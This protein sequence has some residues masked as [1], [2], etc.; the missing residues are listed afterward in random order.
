MILV[1]IDCLII[2]V[3][4]LSFVIPQMTTSGQLGEDVRPYPST[5][6]EKMR[7]WAKE[8]PTAGLNLQCNW[9]CELNNDVN[10]HSLSYYLSVNFEFRNSSVDHVWSTRGEC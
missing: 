9:Y 7:A 5:P 6:T 10:G 3:L 1:V 2:L 8:L 4:N